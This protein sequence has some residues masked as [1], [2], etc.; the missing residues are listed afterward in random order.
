MTDVAGWAMMPAPANG[1]SF[2]ESFSCEHATEPAA[3]I[4]PLLNRQG[5]LM[6]QT[7]SDAFDMLVTLEK[8]PF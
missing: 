6:H 2:R 3:G 4:Q 1:R 7:S 8:P 5:D